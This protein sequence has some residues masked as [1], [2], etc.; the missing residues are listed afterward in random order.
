MS[1]IEQ[2]YVLCRFLSSTYLL[3]DEYRDLN[4]AGMRQSDVKAAATR[5]FESM[6]E[7]WLTRQDTERRAKREAKLQKDRRRQRK[8]RVSTS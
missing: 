7:Q 2:R 5:Y 4:L 3:A 8:R 1:D 6:R